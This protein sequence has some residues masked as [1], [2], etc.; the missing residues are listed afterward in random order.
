M[1]PL[2]LFP[3]PHSLELIW[4]LAKTDFS[5][6]YNGSFLGFVWVLLKPLFTFLI[7]NFVFSNIFGNT[8]EYSLGLFVGLVMWNFFAEGTLIGMTSLINKAHILTKVALPKWILVLASILNTLL[9]FSLTLVIVALFFVY[10][11]VYPDAFSVLLSLGY[12]LVVFAL[13]FAFSLLASP[14]FVRF[15]DLNQI[16]EV[17]LTGGFYAAP[18]I[19]PFEILPEQ[20]QKVLYVLNPMTFPI[21][22]VKAL[23]IQDSFVFPERHLIYIGLVTLALIVG[24]LSFRRASR[25]SAQ[26]V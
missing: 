18:I 6:R 11:G 1:A 14:L 25:T 21:A 15:R 24:F 8:K 7:L 4:I 9:N 22:N 23:L 3:V 12:C 26:Y 20:A 17:L 5:L 10:Y 2:P 13:I 19:F 16:W